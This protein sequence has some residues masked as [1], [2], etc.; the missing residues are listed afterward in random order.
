[1]NEKKVLASSPG[2]LAC[3]FMDLGVFGSVG[4]HLPSE[5]LILPYFSSLSMVAVS[6]PFPEVGNRKGTESGL[7]GAGVQGGGSHL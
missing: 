4:T 1:M 3:A 5:K 6:V 2:P 7:V